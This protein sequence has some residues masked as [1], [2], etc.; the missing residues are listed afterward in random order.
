MPKEKVIKEN[1]RVHEKEAENYEDQQPEIYNEREQRRINSALKWAKGNIDTDSFEMKAL[2]LGCGTG[3]ILEKLTPIFDKVIGMDLSGEMLSVAQSEHFDEGNNVELV[4]GRASKLPF[5]ENH[6]D[7]VSFYSVLHHFPNFIGPISEASRVLRPGGI[8]YIDHE[9][10]G[11]ENLLVRLYIKF[12]DLLNGKREE[13]LPPYEGEE[14]IERSFCD[15]HIH[16]GGN[17]GVP[18]DRIVEICEEEGFE[19]IEEERYL[20]YGSKTKNL[21]YPLLR[22]F[23]NSEW[24][25]IGKNGE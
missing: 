25:Y 9:P 5:P 6:F 16:H 22:P 1:L 15:Y 12:C 24:L 23:T 3:N 17:G 2:D 8:L 19:T 20:I 7:F 4:R 11:R 18:T 21:L 10:I 14:D 13:G